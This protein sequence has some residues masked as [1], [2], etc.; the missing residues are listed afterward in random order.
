MFQSL[1]LFAI[2]SANSRN[3]NN[4]GLLRFHRH[5]LTT[6]E[7]MAMKRRIMATFLNVVVFRSNA[8]EKVVCA[9]DLTV[10]LLLYHHIH[11][12]PSRCLSLHGAAVLHAVTVTLC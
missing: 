10:L 5:H 12:P 2:M 11:G 7:N 9:F 4:L 8:K 1:R 3:S 6:L